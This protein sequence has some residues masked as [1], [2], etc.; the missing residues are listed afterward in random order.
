MAGSIGGMTAPGARGEKRSNRY[1]TYDPLSSFRPANFVLRAVLLMACSSP[2]G[3]VSSATNSQTSAGSGDVRT[4]RAE[5]KARYV[6]AMT[7]ERYDVLTCD[8]P[9]AGTK[10]LNE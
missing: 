1:T 2:D 3:R 8:E 4:T 5:R 9:V 6:F 10:V 7:T